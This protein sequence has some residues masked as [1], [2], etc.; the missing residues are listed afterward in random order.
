MLKRHIIRHFDKEDV[1]T[2]GLSFAVQTNA[3]SN[4]FGSV[5][6]RKQQLKNPHRLKS[7]DRFDIL[8]TSDFNPNS[9][10]LVLYRQ[11]VEKE[12][13][14]PYLVSLCKFFYEKDST[15]ISLS[16]EVSYPPTD[17]ITDKKTGKVLHQCKHCFTIYDED[18][19]DEEGNISPGTSFT[20][21]PEDY[22]CPLCDAG[23]EDFAAIDENQFELQS[24]TY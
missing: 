5:I 12:Y 2:Y 7:L 4:L 11:D 18:L 19:G 6:I 24:K 15:P 22:C 23:K 1:R 16:A 20:D 10:H 13:L 14:G 3:T 17:T 9:S 8:H 21:L